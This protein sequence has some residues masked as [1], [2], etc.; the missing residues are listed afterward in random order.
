M[1]VSYDDFA[2]LFLRKIKEYD[3]ILLDRDL[4]AEMIDSY[5]KSA[6][7]KFSH[8]CNYDLTNRDDITRTFTFDIPQNKIDEIIDIITDGMIEEWLKPYAYN[9]ENLENLINTTD[10]STY[11]PAELLLRISNLYG[12]AQR[13]FK[14]RCI[15]YSYNYGDL[16]SLHL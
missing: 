1:I 10:F 3:F 5:M 13:D 9:S 8:V 7:I 6:C 14:N 12:K 16:T 11:S 15:G 2:K 4:S